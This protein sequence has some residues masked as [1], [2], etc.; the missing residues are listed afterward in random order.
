MP[1]SYK[2]GDTWKAKDISKFWE[3]ENSGDFSMY[4]I[5]ELNDINPHH[6]C[7]ICVFGDKKLRDKILRILIAYPEPKEE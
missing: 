4:T 2:R 3:P 1:K 7:K 6:F 5:D